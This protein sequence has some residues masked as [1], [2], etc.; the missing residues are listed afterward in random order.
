VAATP[1]RETPGDHSLRGRTADTGGKGLG[2]TQL[3]VSIV[4]YM[5]GGIYGMILYAHTHTTIHIYTGYVIIIY[6]ICIYI[7]IINITWF[8]GFYVQIRNKT[9]RV[10]NIRWGL[11]PTA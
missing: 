6:I 5:F 2:R 9:S 8:L 4:G 1:G 11:C 3:K 10:S 7:Y